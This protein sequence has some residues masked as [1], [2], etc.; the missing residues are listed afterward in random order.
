MQCLGYC[1]IPVKRLLGITPAT[2][3]TPSQPAAA[4]LQQHRLEKCWALVLELMPVGPCGR[5]RRLPSRHACRAL[6]LQHTH[7][8]ARK[9]QALNPRWL[10]PWCAPPLH[11]RQ[12]CHAGPRHEGVG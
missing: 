8:P 11:H 10:A 2:V 7:A 3:L 5:A 6:R 12:L 9:P 1:A 4:W